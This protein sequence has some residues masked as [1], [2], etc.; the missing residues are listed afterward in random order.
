MNS[1][2][3]N[4][5]QE[6]RLLQF[7]LQPISHVV[8]L[9]YFFTLVTYE[10]K[11]SIDQMISR[12][13]INLFPVRC[14]PVSSK[15][16]ECYV[17]QLFNKRGNKQWSHLHFFTTI[18]VFILIF[19]SV[20]DEWLLIVKTD[21]GCNLILSPMIN[22]RQVILNPLFLNAKLHIL[23]TCCA[24]HYAGSFPIPWTSH[25]QQRVIFI[26]FGVTK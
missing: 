13:L 5:S 2:S 9:G 18:S 10:S 26:L 3:I 7:Q 11:V 16:G 23:N 6:S 24:M 12:N 22:H 8:W 21:I 4:W 14:Y 19:T 25:H 15:L 1:S 20:V 17:R